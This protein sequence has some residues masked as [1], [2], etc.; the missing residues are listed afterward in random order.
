MIHNASSPREE[1]F[2]HSARP[3][4]TKVKPEKGSGNGTQKIPAKGG[5]GTSQQH[6]NR[7]VVIGSAKDKAVGSRAV[8][9]N[10]GCSGKGKRRS[11]PIRVSEAMFSSQPQRVDGLRA[12]NPRSSVASC[13]NNSTSQ[14]KT[15]AS[16]PRV[17]GLEQ[18]PQDHLLHLGKTSLLGRVQGETSACPNTQRS[19][20]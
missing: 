10:V 4:T 16:T 19:S 9:R 12:S 15:S 8:A 11:N 17:G 14:E 2:G 18:A 5:K 3:C 1:I 6:Q 13:G 20:N 7:G